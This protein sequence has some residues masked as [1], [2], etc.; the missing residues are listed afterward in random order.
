M[1]VNKK[2]TLSGHDAFIDATGLENGIQVV[3][4][5]VSVRGFTIKNANGEG[6]LVGVD[7]PSDE[8]LLPASG[9]ILDHVTIDDNDVLNNNKGFNGT[10]MPN[11]KYPGDC[12]GGIHFNVTTHSV[13]SGNTVNGNSDGIVLTDDYGPSSY[14]VVEH[15]VVDDNLIR[16]RVTDTRTDATVRR[17]IVDATYMASRV[18]ATDPP[19][20]EVN[21]GTTCVP[22][23]ALTSVAKPPA[24]YVIIGAGKTGDRC[25]VSAPRSG[26]S[27]RRH[28]LD[29]RS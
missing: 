10:E 28:H 21:D 12:G 3:A 8:H 27:T 17:R 15:N 1:L 14:N 6:I 20:F 4:S 9:P 23:G 13:A 18:P 19:P 16:S 26:H 7:A 2:L 22:V 5:H 24:G 11:C 25:R 29:P